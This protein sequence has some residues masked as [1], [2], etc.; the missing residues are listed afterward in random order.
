MT[1][2]LKIIFFSLFGISLRIIFYYSEYRDYLKSLLIF[3]QAPYNFDNIKENYIYN[4][5]HK[6]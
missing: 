2:I 6:T 3:D 5:F 1:N 4:L